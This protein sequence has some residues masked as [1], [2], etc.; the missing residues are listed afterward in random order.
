MYGKTGTSQVLGIE[1]GTLIDNRELEYNVLKP[2]N[3]HTTERYEEHFSE[4][5]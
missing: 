2:M 1:K 3:S 5:S 4:G